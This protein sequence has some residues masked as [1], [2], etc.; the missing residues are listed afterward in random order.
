MHASC[1]READK[2][3]ET[4]SFYFG[5]FFSFFLFFLF[6]Q[7][8]RQLSRLCNQQIFSYNLMLLIV[9]GFSRRLLTAHLQ[10]YS[11]RFIG[12]ACHEPLHLHHGIHQQWSPCRGTIIPLISIYIVHVSRSMFCCFTIFSILYVS[13]FSV[14]CSSCK[15]LMYFS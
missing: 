13:T 11:L 3:K 8:A 5:F 6:K 2:N 12:Y 14:V 4:K 9:D 10:I 7:L 15:K 1:K